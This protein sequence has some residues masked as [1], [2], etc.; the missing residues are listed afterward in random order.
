DQTARGYLADKWNVP[1]PSVTMDLLAERLA[2]FPTLAQGFGEL[3]SSVEMARYARPAPERM[4][5]LL[6]KA[7]EL[8]A[9]MEKEVGR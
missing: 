2:N 7:R 5:L 6:E 3:L 8:V 1:A 4:K 9:A